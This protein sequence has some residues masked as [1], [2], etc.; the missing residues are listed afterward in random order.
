VFPGGIVEPSDRAL[1]ERWFGDAEQYLRA[2]AVRE[3]AEETGLVPVGNSDGAL[4]GEPS[5]W[6]LAPGRLP[7][8]GRVPPMPPPSAGRLPVLARWIA[9]EALPVRFDATFFAV[10]AP[11]DLDP[12]PDGVE[13]DRAW[14]AGPDDVLRAPDVGGRLMWPTLKMLEA[15]AG[16]RSVDEVLALRVDQVPPPIAS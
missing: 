3:L 7:G 2:C 15:M 9:P 10:A 11:R 5:P 14:W 12:V 8:D 4:S 1:A 13:I 16:C 6:L